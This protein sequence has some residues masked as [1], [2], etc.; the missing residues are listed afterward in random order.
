MLQEK[1]L[2]PM[3]AA[4]FPCQKPRIGF[5]LLQEAYRLAHLCCLDPQ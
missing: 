1:T 4:C 5:S 3:V 2:Q